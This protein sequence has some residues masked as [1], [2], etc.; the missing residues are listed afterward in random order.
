MSTESKKPREFGP[1]AEYRAHFE[2]WDAGNPQPTPSVTQK[3]Q[4]PATAPQVAV[5]TTPATSLEVAAPY[6]QLAPSA[7]V[8]TERAAVV[9]SVP[10]TTQQP[11]APQASIIAP[12][13]AI[14]PPPMAQPPTSAPSAPEQLAKPP[15]HAIISPPS[16]P[17][18]DV[19]PP[20]TA[21]RRPTTPLAAKP[22]IA[23]DDADAPPLR[24]GRRVW[25]TPVLS[26]G[27]FPA[28][29]PNDS[30]ATLTVRLTTE[31]LTIAAA[32]TGA[33]LALLAMRPWRYFG[34][35]TPPANLAT[36]SVAKPAALPM[37]SVAK[38][39]SQAAKAPIAAASHATI[40]GASHTIVP[41]SVKVS[42]AALVK[43]APAAS[44]VAA[45]PGLTGAASVKPAAMPSVVAAAGPVLVPPKLASVQPASA[46]S[47]ATSQKSVPPVAVAAVPAVK[48]IAKPP[49]PAPSTEASPPDDIEEE[50]DEP[51]ATEHPA[52]PGDA[53][54]DIA[55]VRA[56]LLQASLLGQMAQA[57]Y[58]NL[59]LSVNQDGDVFLDGTFL[60]QADQD[61]MIAMIRAHPRVRD[62]YFS[63]TVWYADQPTPVALPGKAGAPEA[64]LP[65]ASAKS[66]G[67]FQPAAQP[68]H[69]KIAHSEDFPITAADETPAPQSPYGAPL[70]GAP[71]AKPSAPSPRTS[72]WPFR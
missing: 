37:P 11:A 33:L 4:G 24:N 5:P 53:D 71:N 39:E 72:I 10:F 38:A 58:P 26:T 55:Q 51:E 34:A 65:P 69:L 25:T 44:S 35:S 15:E 61:R 6:S 60:N 8:T 41:A 49:Q 22:N 48:A 62:I 16:G 56:E 9:E 27:A 64:V 30:P 14:S 36:Q 12:E 40:A 43:P 17:P 32:V 31:Q 2:L 3:G 54:S 67:A 42:A 45:L 68:G 1:V 46:P 29:Q 21:A 66:A 57:G 59:G 52:A 20:P 7:S 50:P 19:G 13:V 28:R 47:A 70:P 23:I 18:A 63:G